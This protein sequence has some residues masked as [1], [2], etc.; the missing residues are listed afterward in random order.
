MIEG[1]GMLN[2]AVWGRKQAILRQGTEPSDRMFVRFDGGSKDLSEPL[3]VC[4][5]E[6]DPIA[7]DRFIAERLPVEIS[8][9]TPAARIY[10][11]CVPL[12]RGRKWFTR[13]EEH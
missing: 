12:R 6:G 4:I 3:R 11:D 9:N 10:C 5:L 8:F 2:E 7:L 1:Y 13:S